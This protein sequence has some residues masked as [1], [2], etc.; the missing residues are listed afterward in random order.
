MKKYIIAASATTFI[1]FVTLLILVLREDNKE[2]VIT[3]AGTNITY[4]EG[5]DLKALLDYVTAKD[6][7]DGDVT[8][9]VM[10]A[11]ILPMTDS[12][13]A[14]VTYMA[15]DSSNNIA[16][17]DIIV[18]FILKTE[19]PKESED[20]GNTIDKATDNIKADDKVADEITLNVETANTSQ[21][22]ETLSDKVV[23]YPYITLSSNEVHLNLGDELDPLSF[24]ETA[25]DDKDTSY[26]LNSRMQVVGTYD[27]EQIGTYVI[28]YSTTDLEM[29][30]SNREYLT[31][32]VE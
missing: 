3:V 24:V 25:Q 15:K 19:A 30:E 21:T 11:D 2:P 27:L 9:S 18:N 12:S 32:F 28:M 1:L 20:E 29:N 8:D 7:K 16:K 31:I 4:T 23:S 10:V 17:E 22:Q 14:K 6:D 5:E 26:L 13:T